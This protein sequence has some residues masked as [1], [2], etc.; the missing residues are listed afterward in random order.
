[1]LNIL[2]LFSGIGITNQ[3][4]TF[5]AWDKVT[6]KPLHNAIEWSDARTHDEVEAA[7]DRIPNRNKDHFRNRTGLPISTAFWYTKVPWLIKNNSGVRQALEEKRLCVGSVETW[8]LWV[9]DAMITDTGFSLHELVVDG[10]MTDNE[11]VMQIQADFLGI[12]IVCPTLKETT[13][14]GAALMAGAAA[15]ID[16]FK[17]NN[18]KEEVLV[19]YERKAETFNPKM[20]PEGN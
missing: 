4:A 10:G 20:T 6:G 12:P 1:M 7:L 15:G 5:I 11:L 16:I 2:E 18:T 19:N 17:L 8:L 9:V 3:M 14:F 13:A